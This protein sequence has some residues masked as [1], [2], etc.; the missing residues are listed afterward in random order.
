MVG[1]PPSR[2]TRRLTPPPPFRSS[3]VRRRSLTVMLGGPFMSALYPDGAQFADC[4]R[5][6][7]PAFVPIEPLA[8]G[9]TAA[10]RLTYSRP[11]HGP[12]RIPPQSAVVVLSLMQDLAYGAVRASSH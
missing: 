2:T 7:A 11:G 3:L 12:A 9:G 1:L 6:D 8:R 5:T 4:F 10:A